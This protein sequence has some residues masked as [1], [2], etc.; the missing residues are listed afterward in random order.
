MTNNHWLYPTQVL[1]LQKN[2]KKRRGCLCIAKCTVPVVDG[3]A[4]VF[5]ELA[6]AV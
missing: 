1:L 2:F 3:D 6:K 4:Q 5:A